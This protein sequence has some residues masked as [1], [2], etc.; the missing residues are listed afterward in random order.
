MP[1]VPLGAN[2]GPNLSYVGSLATL[3]CRQVLHAREHPPSAR[4]YLR[5]GALA[6]PACLIVGVAALWP[7]LRISTV[8]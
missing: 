2:I 8:R 1:A 6:E 4:D 7:G 3:L 5:L